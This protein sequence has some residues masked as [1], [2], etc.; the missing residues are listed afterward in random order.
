[1]PSSYFISD[2]TEVS[3][4]CLIIDISDPQNPNV[5][6]FIDKCTRGIDVLGTYAYISSFNEGFQIVDIKDPNTPKIIGSISDPDFHPGWVKVSGNHAFIIGDSFSAIN[7]SDPQ[8]PYIVD[9][10]KVGEDLHTLFNSDGAS[11]LEINGNM[12]YIGG[13]RITVIDI[14]DPNNLVLIDSLPAF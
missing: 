7:V 11:H 6:S 1:M 10:L 12:A 2:D 8:N 4:G 13:I 5:V 14:S 3:H 9:S